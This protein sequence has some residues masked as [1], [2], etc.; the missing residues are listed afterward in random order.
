MAKVAMLTT[1]DNPF[2]PFEQFNSWFMF[3]CEKGYNSYGKLMRLAEISEDMSSV[4]YD[5][6]IEEAIDKLIEI[7]FLDIFKKVTREVP[8][9]V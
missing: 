9:D 2:D 4:E 5:K 3:D 6:A 7:D 1:V 8:D